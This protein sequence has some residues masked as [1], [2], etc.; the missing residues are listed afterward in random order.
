M[1][2]KTECEIGKMKTRNKEIKCT[3]LETELFSASGLSVQYSVPL[4]VCD[5]KLSSHQRA[6]G[7]QT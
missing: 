6:V 4:G 2:Y 7:L 3:C 1:F 5:K